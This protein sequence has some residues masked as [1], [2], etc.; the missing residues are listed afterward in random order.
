MVRTTATAVIE[1]HWLVEAADVE[2][3]K[4]TVLGE[5][6]GKIIDVEDNT[7]GDEQDRE[8]CGTMRVPDNHKLKG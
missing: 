1:E 2:D 6:N 8:V 7:L 5:G 4:N 3:A